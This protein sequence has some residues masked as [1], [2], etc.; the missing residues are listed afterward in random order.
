MA[1]RNSKASISTI[2][3][4][5]VHIEPSSDSIY[6]NLLKYARYEARIKSLQLLI[7]KLKANP[8]TEINNEYNKLKKEL[9]EVK[10]KCRVLEEKNMVL[11][12]ELNRLNEKNLKLKK[13]VEATNKVLHT[14]ELLILQLQ[15]EL[16]NK[17]VSL[18]NMEQ[19]SKKTKETIDS[20]QTAISEYKKV[21]EILQNSLNNDNSSILKKSIDSFQ[22]LE[23]A[24]SYKE[25][26]YSLKNPTI[27]RLSD[28]KFGPLEQR[29]A[30][31]AIQRNDLIIRVGGG[32]VRIDNFLKEISGDKD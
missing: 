17:D 5:E 29:D 1:L 25:N 10:A 30:N 2:S 14:K 27:R 6:G 26:A 4:A 32:Y 15:N 7:N 8:Q 11:D 18:S 23:L 19:E 31:A 21:T 13:E 20:L 24:Q 3:Q 9:N 28:L 16:Y 12:V 22:T